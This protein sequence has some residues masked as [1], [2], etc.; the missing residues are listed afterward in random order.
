LK[1]A[2]Y[3]SDLKIN[4]FNSS[5]LIESTRLME[6]YFSMGRLPKLEKL[7]FIIESSVKIQLLLDNIEELTEISPSLKKL[8]INIKSTTHFNASYIAK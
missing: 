3:L 6:F 8:K 7:E 1:Y 2:K 4:I 5:E